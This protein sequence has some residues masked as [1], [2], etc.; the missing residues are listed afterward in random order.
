MITDAAIVRVSLAALLISGT[1]YMTLSPLYEE[2]AM[3][4]IVPALSVPDF[5]VAFAI[6]KRKAWLNKWLRPLAIGTLLIAVPFWG[7][8]SEFYGAFAT[9]M[10]V[11]ESTL[12]IAGVC[13]LLLSF[14]PAFRAGS[15]AG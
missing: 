4:L 6:W 11:A 9:P 13:L 15:N 10:L 14:R 7:R 3:R 12:V 1:F 5:V 8:S 2:G